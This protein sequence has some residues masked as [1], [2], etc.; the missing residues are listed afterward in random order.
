MHVYNNTF[1]AIPAPEVVFKE[2]KY[3]FPIDQDKSDFTQEEILV[4]FGVK[5][6][7]ELLATWRGYKVHGVI[8]AMKQTV[9]GQGTYNIYRISPGIYYILDESGSLLKFMILFDQAGDGNV[10]VDVKSETDITMSYTV[11]KQ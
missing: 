8:I 11:S 1:V 5:S 7:D 2:F 10:I 9:E 3:N 4:A 6:I